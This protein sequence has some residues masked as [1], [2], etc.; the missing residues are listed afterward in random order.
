[1]SRIPV[2]VLGATGVVCQRCIRR[3]AGQPMF[4]VPRIAASERSAGLGA[5][6]V[7]R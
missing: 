4:E 7:L 5:L 3:L 1:M 6:G 2:T